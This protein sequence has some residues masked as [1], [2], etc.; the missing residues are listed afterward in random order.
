MKHAK[1][2]ALWDEYSNDWLC[3][4]TVNI[5][6]ETVSVATICSIKKGYDKILL[7][8]YNRMKAIVKEA[9]FGTD[10]K[11]VNRYKRAAI[12]AYAI[13]SA[14]PLEYKIPPAFG[15]DDLYL[16]QRLAIQ[17]ALGS[18]V[19]DFPEDKV[20]ELPNPLFEFSDLG[21]LNNKGLSSTQ[22]DTQQD[23]FLLSLY[24]DLFFAEIHQNYNVLTMANVFG[25][26]TEKCSKLA[27]LR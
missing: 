26:L 18:I 5:N 24:K 25:L 20:C 9:Y 13:S 6:N 27:L 7:K 23:D 21:F 12:L 19:V 8:R 4:E 15:A 16:K 14:E 11:H 17:V 10:V 1:L 22:G 3:N 2:K